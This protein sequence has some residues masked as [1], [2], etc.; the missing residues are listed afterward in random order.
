MAPNAYLRQRSKQSSVIR[1]TFSN[2]TFGPIKLAHLKQRCN[3]GQL[4]TD[5]VFFIETTSFPGTVIW[6]ATFYYPSKK[7]KLVLLILCMFLSYQF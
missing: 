1:A 7:K 6:K 5:R 3:L 4:N 2:V